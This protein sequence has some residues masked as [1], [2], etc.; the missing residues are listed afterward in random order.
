[1]VDE[2]GR[3]HELVSAELTKGVRKQLLLLALKRTRSIADAEDLVQT[4]CARAAD[5]AGLPF[6][7]AK[8]KSFVLHVGSIINGLALNEIRSG[9][10]RHEVIDTNLARDENTVD[11][12]PLPVEALD[13][14][15]EHAVHLKLGEMLE[16]ELQA[17]DPFAASVYRRLRDVAESPSELAAAFGCRVE[18]VY[19]AKNRIKYHAR[20]LLDQHEQAE[21]RRLAELRSR[22]PKGAMKKEEVAR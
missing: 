15:R 4:A 3:L 2:R 9:R 5:P 8:G 1:M 13:E 7:P 20:R 18:E 17:K 6:D 21:E 12:A 22:A 19:D 16:T 10:A 14:A 11:G